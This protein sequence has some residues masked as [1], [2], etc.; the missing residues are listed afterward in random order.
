MQIVT[1]IALISIN[2]TLVVQL[3]SFLIF[4]FIINRVMI[5]PL[6]SASREREAHVERISRDISEAEAKIGQLTRQIRAEEGAVRETALAAQADLEEAGN[7]EAADMFAA[8]RGEIA[9][10]REN[11][12][13]EIA[14]QMASA[15]QGV[16]REAETLALTV[17]EKILNR[18]LAA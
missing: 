5:R 16:Q 13:E 17:M 12:Q 10:I 9:A 14:S 1:N 7:R 4:L 6:R 3:I 8:A 2:E 11:A 15:R 18:R